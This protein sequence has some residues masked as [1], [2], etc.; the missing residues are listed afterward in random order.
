M[1]FRF[2]LATI[3]IAMLWGSPL[4]SQPDDSVNVSPEVTAPATSPENETVQDW[5]PAPE[6]G[7]LRLRLTLKA[8]EVKEGLPVLASL[9]I[10]NFGADTASYSSAGFEHLI[11]KH[12]NGDAD[13]YLASPE[14]TMTRSKSL[15]PGQSVF[16]WKDVDVGKKYLLDQGQYSVQ[17]IGSG[18]RGDKAIPES[19]IQTLK[20]SKGQQTPQK[21][22]MKSLIAVAPRGWQ[23]SYNSYGMSAAY[24]HHLDKRPDAPKKPKPMRVVGGKVAPPQI[25]FKVVPEP[26]PAEKVVENLTPL[27][28]TEMGY[29]YVWADEKITELWPEHIAKIREAAQSIKK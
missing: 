4:F 16:I 24:Y 14:G 28:N 27:G 1:N 8:N 10:K 25:S 20:I 12:V 13:Q 3:L 11:V 26:L 15:Q 6:Q 5:G 23:V 17:V 2:T 9:E 18:W 22:F 29:L 21:R 19:N 7:D